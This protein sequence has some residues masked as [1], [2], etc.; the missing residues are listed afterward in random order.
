[1]KR[2]L[3]SV[4][5]CLCLIFGLLPFGAMADH[6]CIDEN[7]DYYCDLCCYG[8]AHD[9]VDADGDISCDLCGCVMEHECIDEDGDDRCDFC[10]M[11]LEGNNVPLT[12]T[13]TS[14]LEEDVPGWIIVETPFTGLVN[15]FTGTSFSEP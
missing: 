13:V 11:N 10:G 8:I 9:C 6:P 3:L 14:Y 7:S 12:I 5:L 4:A 15:W 2:R 1:M